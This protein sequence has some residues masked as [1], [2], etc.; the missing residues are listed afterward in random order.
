VHEDGAVTAE[1]RPGVLLLERIGR[2]MD[3]VRRVGLTVRH[4][5]LV[6]LHDLLQFADEAL[7]DVGVDAHDRLDE[8]FGL[9]QSLFDGRHHFNVAVH[10]RRRRQ[11]QPPPA[12]LGSEPVDSG[13]DVAEGS[14]GPEI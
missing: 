1:E 8:A 6:S 13:Q 14:I 2:R 10:A 4:Q 11:V 9:D 7:V 3:D 5:A 12:V